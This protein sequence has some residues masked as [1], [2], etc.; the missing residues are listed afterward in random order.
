ML[1]W[2][3]HVEPGYAKLTT[4]CSKLLQFTPEL[5]QVAKNLYQVVPKLS[6]NEALCVRDDP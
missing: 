4:G 2:L 1:C 5:Y 3:L 6:L